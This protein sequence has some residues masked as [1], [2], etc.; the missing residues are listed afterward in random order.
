M[1][2]AARGNI[3]I[4]NLIDQGDAAAAGAGD[5]RDPLEP[6]ATR[7]TY[8]SITAAH[9]RARPAFPRGMRRGRNDVFFDV[10][11]QGEHKRGGTETPRLP[12][13]VC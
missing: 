1:P 2:A 3:A 10:V 8:R 4:Q 12:A 9:R 7:R 5:L 11:T 13:G 6:S